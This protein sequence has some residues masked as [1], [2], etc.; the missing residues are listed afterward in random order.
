MRE[1]FRANK[2]TGAFAPSSKALA[3]IVTDYADLDRANVIVEYGPGTGVFTRAIEHKM[4]KDALFIALEVNEEFVKATQKACKRVHVYHDGAQNASKYLE[5]HGAACC[6]TVISGLPWSRF[7]DQ[8]QD[9]ILEATFNL[10]CPGGKFITFAYSASP[11]LPSGKKFFQGKL[12]RRFPHVHKS[13][14]IWKNFPPSVV[15]LCEKD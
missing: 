6:D 11:Y 1:V 7:S 5:K 10:L 12:Q 9:E 13:R 15:Y 8:L 14:Q 4:K 3:D 2:S